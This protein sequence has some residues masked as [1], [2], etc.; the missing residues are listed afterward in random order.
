MDVLIQGV[1][2]I[3]SI[4]TA[5]RHL[6]SYS[7]SDRLVPPVLQGLEPVLSMAGNLYN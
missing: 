1:R 5:T 4:Q 7:D 6:N 3:S 2:D